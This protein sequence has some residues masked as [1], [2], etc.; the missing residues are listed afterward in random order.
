MLQRGKFIAF[1]G[2]DGSGKSSQMTLLARQ[3]ENA[4]YRVY[5]TFE[6]TDNRIGATIRSVLKGKEQADQLTIAALFAAD[7]LHHLLNEK[8]GICKKLSEGYIVLCDRYY[9]SSYAYHSVYV[10]MDW[11]IEINKK[12]ADI[13]RPDLNIFIDVSPEMAF[14]RI[15]QNRA[16]TELY[17]TPEMLKKVYVNY[18]I[19]FERMRSVEQII[20]I[21]GERE[22]P[23]IADDVWGAVRS[24]LSAEK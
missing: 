14:R 22:I 1:E 5:C 12:S 21:P 10:D 2:I 18:D 6:P 8:D 20:R 3:L 17:E 13:L 7:R 23:A 11:V 4:G 15:Q 24:L 9:F 16:Q 19:A